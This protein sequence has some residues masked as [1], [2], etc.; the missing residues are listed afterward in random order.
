MKRELERSRSA[1]FSPGSEAEGENSEMGKEGEDGYGGLVFGDVVFGYCGEE[2]NEGKED[3][4][5]E[6][7]IEMVGVGMIKGRGRIG[8]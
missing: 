2:D 6:E 4:V 3:T 7:E 5:A 1:S 8:Y